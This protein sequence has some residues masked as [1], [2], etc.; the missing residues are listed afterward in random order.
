MSEGGWGV[1]SVFLEV[2]TLRN[3]RRDPFSDRLGR[4]RSGWEIREDRPQSTDSKG[5]HVKTTKRKG[6]KGIG[7]GEVVIDP[8]VVT[9]HYNRLRTHPLWTGTLLLRDS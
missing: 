6:E 3:R 7:G 9:R 8:L 2:S 5:R 1:E 4:M